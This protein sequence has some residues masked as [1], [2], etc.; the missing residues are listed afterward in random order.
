MMDFD[1]AREQMVDT[2]VR[3]NSVSNHAVIGQFLSVPRERFVPE[4]RMALAYIDDDVAV[5]ETTEGDRNIMN[6]MMLSKLVQFAEV[7]STHFVLDIGCASGY[8]SAIFSGLA[9]SV[10][11]VEAHVDLVEKATNTLQDLGCDNVA[12]VT[13]PLTE[14]CPSEAPFDVIFLGGAVEVVPQTLFDQLRDGG[15]LVTVEGHGNAGRAMKYRKVGDVVSSEEGFNASVKPLPGFE[16][17]RE[18]VF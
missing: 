5:A 2:Q 14:G 6:A 15:V 9:E 18:F 3:P 10:V 8:S 12:V 11:A 13:R 4:D 17:P 7:Q 1:A 16:K